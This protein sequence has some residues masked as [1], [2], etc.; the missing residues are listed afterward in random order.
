MATLKLISF[1]SIEIYPFSFVRKHKIYYKAKWKKKLLLNFSI[2]YCNSKATQK[3]CEVL[4]VRECA[5]WSMAFF[6]SVFLFIFLFFLQVFSMKMKIDFTYMYSFQIY[7]KVGQETTCLV[8][9][10]L[11]GKILVLIFVLIK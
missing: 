4:K 5:G 11:C 6:Y 3:V 8:F 9:I 7:Y 10:C 2:R 1:L